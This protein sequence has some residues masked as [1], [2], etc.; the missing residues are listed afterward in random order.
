MRRE[1]YKC[2]S[3]ANPRCPTSF[4]CISLVKTMA[5]MLSNNL[6][7]AKGMTFKGIYTAVVTPFVDGRID[8]NSLRRVVEQQI[9]RN[10]WHC[11][12]WLAGESARLVMTKFLLLRERYSLCRTV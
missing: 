5:I 12:I 10:P 11:C 4:L 1:F 9:R 2:F 3:G 7:G 8:T 6:S